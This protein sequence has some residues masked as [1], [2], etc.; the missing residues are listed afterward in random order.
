MQIYEWILLLLLILFVGFF[1]IITYQSLIQSKTIFLPIT[2][3]LPFLFP[4]VPS[5]N[6]VNVSCGQTGNF[7]NALFGLTCVTQ[8]LSPTGTTGYCVCQNTGWTLCTGVGCTDLTSNPNSCGSCNNRCASGQI[9]CNGVCVGSTGTSNCGTCG[10]ICSGINPRCCQNKCVDVD[11]DPLNCGSC[12]QSCAKNSFC[13]AGKCIPPDSKNCGGCNISCGP[14]QK[15]QDGKCVSGCDPNSGLTNCNGVCKNLLTD[16]NSCGA[17]NVP[18]PAGSFCSSGVCQSMTCPTNTVF[19]PNL[20]ACIQLSINN[21][22][23]SCSTI[24]PLYCTGQPV[25]SC[26]CSTNADC[27]DSFKCDNSVVPS[28]CRPPTCQNNLTFCS[29]TSQ[30]EDL[31]SSARACGDCSIK[32]APGQSCSAGVCSCSESSDCSLG[33]DC[34]NQRCVLH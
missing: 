13:C 8:N 3:P 34:V 18:C 2:Q 21:A 19:C 12:L 33:Y 7:C 11:N 26:A 27:P 16:N 32:C 23:G 28:I 1:T 15:C 14:N 25:G 31:Q 4:N 20:G 6:V 9:C 24:C 22:C 5:S 30:C 29:S 10:N 17:C